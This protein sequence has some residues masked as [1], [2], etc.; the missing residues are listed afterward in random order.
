[1]KL[2]G[3]IKWF[4]LLAISPLMVF[5]AFA[6]ISCAAKE[7]VRTGNYDF[8]PPPSEWVPLKGEDGT[9]LFKRSSPEMGITVYTT[10][11]RYQ[12]APLPPLAREMF[13]GFENRKI[14]DKGEAKVAGGDAYYIIM[15]CTLDG[16][17]VKVKVYVFKAKNCIY[18]LAYFAPPSNFDSGL[19]TFEKFVSEFK[20]Q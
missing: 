10:C 3:K 20:V 5:S 19:G 13:I 9:L 1:M 16:V 4:L 2:R 7:T 12:S 17:P 15:D 14:L 11:D 18:D 8:D 6:F